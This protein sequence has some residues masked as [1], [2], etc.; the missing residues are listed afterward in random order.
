MTGPHSLGVIG[1]IQAIC[2][3]LAQHSRGV[4]RADE[5]LLADC[6]HADATVDYRFYGGSAK[7]FA[8]ILAG[9]QA[10]QSVT[11]HRT[12]QM[13]I[14]VD[15]TKAKSESYVV[16]YAQ[17]A[18]PDGTMRQRLICGR[19][20]DRHEKRGGAWRLS[21]RTYVLDTNAN[22]PGEFHSPA[23]GQLTNQVPGGGQGPR[24][25]GIALLALAKARNVAINGG[26]A[27]VTPIID[28]DAADAII[29]RQQIADLTMAYCRG[30]D[31]AD[32]PLLRGIFHDDSVI[33]SGI[34]NGN[35]QTFAGEICRFV[36]ATFEQTF[37]SIANQ[38][39]EVTG[40]TAVGETYILAVATTHGTGDGQSEMLS[41][42]RYIDRFERR[43]G[44][45]KIAERIYVEDWHRVDRA[46]RQMAGGM[47]APLDLHGCR[48]Q[49]DPVYAFWAGQ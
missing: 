20:L 47:Y 31:R 10:G 12:G 17:S 6:Y 49:N 29:S 40:D 3:R 11:L 33:V 45:W 1:D 23:L 14:A 34:V 42:G 9:A 32:E 2:N 46:T 35:G 41:G 30:V 22:W 44:I 7:V 43:E 21:H 25:A 4:D 26:R 24:D 5:G 15:G 48:G 36:Q 18:D 16:A 8:G 13:W 27:A 19:Y 28:P 39:I 37:H 38:W